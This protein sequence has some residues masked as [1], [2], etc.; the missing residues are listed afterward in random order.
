MASSPPREN[1][2]SGPFHDG[3]EKRQAVKFLLLMS[4]Y[5]ADS[6]SAVATSRVKLNINFRG[7]QNCTVIDGPVPAS[8]RSSS[9]YLCQMTRSSSLDIDNMVLVMP[10]RVCMLGEPKPR[11]RLLHRNDRTDL[12]NVAMSIRKFTLIRAL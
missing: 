8:G 12:V 3:A 9:N 11:K 10:G 6:S 1:N 7:Q 4:W 5:R 2:L